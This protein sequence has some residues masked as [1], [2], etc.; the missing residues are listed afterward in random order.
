MLP[1]S[2]NGK[3][4]NQPRPRPPA[5][6]H[7]SRWEWGA[8]PSRSLQPA[9]SPVGSAVMDAQ[10]SRKTTG[11][12]LLRQCPDNSK[13][14]PTRFRIPPPTRSAEL[15]FGVSHRSRMTNHCQVA[16]P[17]QSWYVRIMSNVAV[18]ESALR[19]R[20]GELGQFL[21]PAPVADFMASLFGPFPRVVRLLDAGAGSGSLTSALVSRLCENDSGVRAEFAH[22][23]QK[24]M[25]Q[26]G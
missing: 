8:R 7:P 16:N 5:V 21:T 13:S 9:S 22:A 10:T 23:R 4:S 19:K 24:Q 2:D 17:C 26:V 18:S 15:R 25:L 12:H 11:R 1:S 20:Q 14:H 3:V 6:P